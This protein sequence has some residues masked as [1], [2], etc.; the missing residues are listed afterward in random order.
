MKAYHNGL[1]EHFRIC[2]RDKFNEI[3]IHTEIYLIYNPFKGL[4]T[5]DWVYERFKYT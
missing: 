3:T 4:Y 2:L 1:I 5:F